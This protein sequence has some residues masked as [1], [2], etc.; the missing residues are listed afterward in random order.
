MAAKKSKAQIYSQ[1]FIYILTIILISF[2]LVYGYNAVQNFKNRA[3]QVS[4][5]KFK[6]DLQNAV[7]SI[8]SDFGSVKR[9]DLQLCS[10]YT[11]ACFV[12]SFESPNIPG[13]IDPI[14]KDSILSSTGKNVFLVENIAK[15]SFFAG[16]ISVE[17][18]VLCIKALNGKISLKLEGKGN[19]A[20]LGQW[21]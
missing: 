17:P 8:S 1:V 11:Q 20:S 16:K 5:L 13:S 10:G 6:N 7:E 4:C 19:H 3:E 18:D 14:I 9:K 12:E 15:E 21:N 2:I